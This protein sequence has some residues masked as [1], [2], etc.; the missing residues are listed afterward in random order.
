MD[1]TFFFEC[2]MNVRKNVSS[3]T[4]YFHTLLDDFL[5]SYIVY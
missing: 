1:I 3:K 5:H 2:N 4:L